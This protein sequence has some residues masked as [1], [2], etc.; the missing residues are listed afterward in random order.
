MAR[1]I[2]TTFNTWS[3]NEDEFEKIKNAI[4]GQNQELPEET[5]LTLPKLQIGASRTFEV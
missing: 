1:D 2:T 4:P 5:E 3:I